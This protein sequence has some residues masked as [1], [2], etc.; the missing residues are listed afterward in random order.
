MRHVFALDRDNG[1]LLVLSSPLEALDSCK[2]VDVQ[3]GFW[4]FFA[5]DGSPLEPRFDAPDDPDDPPGP[6]SLERAM[7]G[8][9]LQERLESVASVKG[10]GFTHVED[11]AELL[12]INRAMRAASQR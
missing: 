11:V 1:D 10:G 7:S 9:W 8:R 4:L 3:D 6:Y 2:P 12:K 5:E